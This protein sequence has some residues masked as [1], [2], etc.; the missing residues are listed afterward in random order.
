MDGGNIDFGLDRDEVVIRTTRRLDRD[1]WSFLVRVAC[2]HGWLDVVK[3]L[4]EACAFE[5][6][7]Q[8]DRTTL[9]DQSALTNKSPL[10][11]A[12]Q[13]GHRDIAMYLITEQKCN[14]YVRDKDNMTPLHYACDGCHLDVVRY[15]IGLPTYAPITDP[16]NRRHEILYLACKHGYA[17]LA[18]AAIE[19]LKC[20]PNV[21]DENGLTPLHYACLHRHKDVYHHPVFLTYNMDSF[22][23][24]TVKKTSRTNLDDMFFLACKVGH[25]GVIKYMTTVLTDS[26]FNP[27]LKD[28]DQ[29]T[30]LYVA[31]QHHH[32]DIVEY[33]IC[34]PSYTP[35]SGDK[36]EVFFTASRLGNLALIKKVVEEKHWNPD[37]RNRDQQTPLYVACL[38]G[39]IDVVEYFI[40]L[41]GYKPT[42]DV[43][44]ALTLFQACK[45][46]HFNI[47]KLSI[48]MDKCDP[49]RVRDKYQRTLLHFV[50]QHGL[51][52]MVQYLID[53]HS[54][55]PDERDE[56]G[57]TP[58]HSACLYGH[59]E[60]VKYLTGLKKGCNL[61]A[62]NSSQRTPLH[63][64]CLR[65]H[66][67]VV[68][69]L[70]SKRKC[71]LSVVDQHQRTPLHFACQYGHISTVRYLCKQG[72]LPTIEDRD[73]R[74]PLHYASQNGYIVVIEYLITTQKCSPEVRDKDHHTPLHF[75]CYNNR[76]DAVKCLLRVSSKTDINARDKDN[77]TPFE[78]IKCQKE[79]HK[80]LHFL[81]EI[82]RLEDDE[83]LRL[84]QQL[85]SS[86][87]WD[88]SQTS[89]N[90]ENALHF[91]SR[92][93]R[94]KVVEYL[95]SET[96]CDV[97]TRNTK[98]E[99]PLLLAKDCDII[100]ELIKHGASLVD[101]HRKLTCELVEEK[102][103]QT[104]KYL[105][106]HK[107]WNPNLV[108][109]GG[110][111]L[112]FACKA[113]RPQIVAYLLSE[114]KCSPNEGSNTGLIPIQL[115][116][117]PE[118][119]FELIRHN[120]DRYHIYR[121]LFHELEE[122]TSC[123][124]IKHLTKPIM[125]W[126]PY[127]PLDNGDTALHYACQANRATIS[128]YLLSEVGC[129]PNARNSKG[130]TPL[131]LTSNPTIIGCLIQHGADLEHTYMKLTSKM[132][133]EVGLD[134]MKCLSTQDTLA[135]NRRT[136][137]GDN[138]LHFVCRANR[139]RM[140]HYLL[141]ET[142]C[143]IDAE[144]YAGEFPLQSTTVDIAIIITNAVEHR[145]L[146]IV[147]HV[148]VRKQE[149]LWNGM[150]LHGTSV[151]HLACQFN[152]SSIVRY[153]LS[154]AHYSPS[155]TNSNGE[156]PI[157]LV[158]DP[159][160][161]RDLIR[162]GAN[163]P[164]VYKTH[165]KVLGAKC[166][167]LQ[168]SINVF[169]VGNPTVGKSTLTSAIKRELSFMTRKFTV[170]KKVRG[171]D[172]KTAG[173]IPHE[174]NSKR[175]GKITLYDLAGQR[176]FYS[177]HICLLQN[178]YQSSPPIFLIV[179]DLC[180]SDK[181]I[182]QNLLFW[183][184]FINNPCASAAG[185]PHVIIVGSHADV[186]K[187]KKGDTKKLERSVCSIVTKS[188]SSHTVTYGGFVPMD[189]RYYESTG[190]T[191]LCRCLKKS[192]DS[193]RPQGTLSFNAHCF[194]LC[195]LDRFH[196]FTAI[197]LKDVKAQ[198]THT[199]SR[200][201]DTDPGIINFIP[202]SFHSLSNI[203][204]E[205]S[206]RGHILFFKD[207]TNIQN[208][209][210]ITNKQA[211]LSDVN[212]T[213]F[214]PDSFKEHCQLAS[215][216][217]VVPLSKLTHHF[218]DHNPKMLVEFLLLLEFCYE[219]TDHQV[220]ELIEE[221]HS[222]E[223][224]YLFFPALIRLEIPDKVW[225][226]NPRFC[227]ACGWVLRC[228]QPEDFFN[229]RFIQVLILRLAFYFAL[230][231]SSG[232]VDDNF[233]AFQRKG[234]V[235][236]SGIFWG[237]RQGVET[238]VEVL[239]SNKEVVML[240]RGQDAN[241]LECLQLRSQVLRR[242]RNTVS[243]LC[244]TI[245]TEE[246]LLEPSAASTYPVQLTTTFSVAELAKAI[247][248]S[249]GCPSVVTPT[250]TTHPVSKLLPF[251]PYAQLGET[252]LIQLCVSEYTS[253][254]SSKITDKFISS[255]THQVS[256]Q[257]EA[258]LFI[259]MLSGDPSRQSL[260]D[261]LHSW[262]ESCGEGTYRELQEKMNQF[263]IFTARDVLVSLHVRYCNEKGVT[264]NTIM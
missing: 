88:P 84:L 242:V 200:V 188:S 69:Y 97:N 251:D 56:D 34:I 181:D 12:C 22:V 137:G 227:Y 60:V 222:Q 264:Y 114:A 24:H 19:A 118:I 89:T 111:A 61:N 132:T 36:V 158:S 115:T 166:R 138:V 38:H 174:F 212:G 45:Q 243:E 144:N 208:S 29:R 223:E 187:A 72:C 75:A 164:D 81:Y 21:R 134:V 64:A 54:C 28:G 95:L 27:N 51:T 140:M 50:C 252:M 123:H 239:P 147:T 256:K 199:D 121:K 103:I 204:H 37:V 244:K 171:V 186:F 128:Q 203:C 178:A 135:L 182:E 70:I 195:L 163:P 151:L 226:P 240:I 80:L 9:Y 218:P 11:Y 16:V 216:T 255:F 3:K 228:S 177:G 168:P 130:M 159:E 52:N 173:V 66:I 65:G 77:K 170:N 119:V 112:H 76:F 73:R 245:K 209:W 40:T 236:K 46:G 92:T 184:S 160:I 1:S 107:L 196:E 207:E 230:A 185:K 143:D 258:P 191:G 149:F 47:L 127:K 8:R 197:R 67:D 78:M 23:R 100:V 44:F 154:E 241:L 43:F 162:H 131:D 110:N 205:L 87:K 26:K 202:T 234:S 136:S 39:H 232:E 14:P 254:Y 126:D 180:D 192:C 102:A 116:N 125:L 2:S 179:I 63:H 213:I 33:L 96:S 229:S 201:W 141:C 198:L 6:T 117:N 259:K 17:S 68:Q 231:P 31:C 7:K 161:V 215:S 18:K 25:I 129:D 175:Y 262:R 30:P 124:I 74:T 93:D 15:L 214:A 59:I 139:P 106:Q 261:A 104:M 53:E 13:G 263:S 94:I 225:E 90:N 167:P 85:I 237:N 220:I 217:G 120:T 219:V 108:C 42:N 250:G 5:P 157:Q 183:L 193:L 249:S 156:T 235:W 253:E 41:P 238:L 99:S 91:A 4:F 247:V 224:K 105:I 257:G 10:H 165:G 146:Q 176:E 246:S 35:D 148:I 48:E 190:M 206:N 169:V 20:H 58:L 233:P 71:N 32:M 109:G 142:N 57:R 122:E 155:I 194:L 145:A 82:T 49:T 172:E 98:G 62:R 83:I 210:I 260:S 101:A 79:I 221:H 55:D 152:K 113:S 211:L 86:N 153:L 150:T 248:V 189:C 133:E